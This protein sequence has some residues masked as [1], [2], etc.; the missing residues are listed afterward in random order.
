[1]PVPEIVEFRLTK[2][3]EA[4]MGVFSSSGIFEFYFLLIA[5]TLRKSIDD[6]L[7]A[8]DSFI[9]DPLLDHNGM[10][11]F[12]PDLSFETIRQRLSFSGFSNIEAGVK[13]LIANAKDNKSLKEMY[14]GWMPHI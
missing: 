1:M 12:D 8:L 14:F 5:K 7:G 6:I 9:Y 11:G 2:N 3:I 13:R 4:P 10:V